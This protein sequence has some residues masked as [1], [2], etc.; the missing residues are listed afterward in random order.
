MSQGF[1]W[2]EWMNAASKH[3]PGLPIMVIAEGGINHNGDV[4]LACELVEM[5]SSCGANAVK[6]QKREPDICVPFEVRDNIRSTP[7]G[8]MTY[9]EYKKLTELSIDEYKIIDQCAKDLRID[10][11]ASA[12]DV[13]SQVLMR[14]FNSPINKVASAMITHLSL[15]T[16]IAAEGKPTFIS[17]GMS[18]L[19]QVDT[20][21]Q[22]FRR[23]DCP[24]VLM[25]TVSSY[26]A[27][28]SDLNLKVMK[29]LED[30]YG[31]AIG[32]SGHETTVSPSVAA[33]AMGAV[34]VE[35]HITLDRTSW[36]T[37]QAASL[38]A[39]GFT[40]LVTILRRLPEVLGDGE[41]RVS[42]SEL[43]AAGNLR[44]WQ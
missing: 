26:P 11:F 32:Y 7:W 42:E 12:W 16:E 6:F 13:P 4:K 5:A 37:D 24:F 8:D 38:E 40:S 44:Y 29:T 34:A 30:R 43:T 31:C 36:G 9:F 23:L 3:T 21:V 17:T 10:W 25:H 20:A 14:Q 1:N 15:L 22:A 2:Q 19:E 18:T 35:R 33:A 39:A 41:K 28:D 27:R